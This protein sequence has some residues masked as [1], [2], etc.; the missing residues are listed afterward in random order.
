MLTLAVVVAV[1]ALLSLLGGRLL[2][3]RRGGLLAL[4]AALLGVALIGAGLSDRPGGAGQMI[5]DL[6]PFLP[7]PA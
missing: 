6:L 3:G 5:V 4:V 1:T 7:P 2:A